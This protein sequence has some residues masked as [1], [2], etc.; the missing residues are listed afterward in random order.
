MPKDLLAEF[1]I[2]TSRMIRLELRIEVFELRVFDAE[3]VIRGILACGGAECPDCFSRAR[4]Y[5][6]KYK[7]AG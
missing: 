5:Q 7:M 6:D 3:E 1:E 4:V 2:L